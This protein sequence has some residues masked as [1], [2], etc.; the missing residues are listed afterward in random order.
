MLLSII[1]VNWNTCDL[2]AQCLQTL[3]QQPFRFEFDIWVVDNASTD[4]SLDMLRRDFPQ[5]RLIANNTNLGFARANNQALAQS[6]AQYRLL[7]NSDAFVTPGAIESMLQLM[8][9]HPKAGLVGAR[10]LNPDGSFQTSFTS[11]PNLWQEFLVLSG[12]GRLFKG[13]WYPS[14]AAQEAQGAQ[15]VDYVSGACLLVRREAYAQVGGMD[16][17]YFMYAEEMDWCFAMR[18]NGWQVWYQPAAKILHVG[19]GSSQKRPIQREA[20]LYCSRVRFFRKHYGAAS[21]EALK[22]MLYGFTTLKMVG[23]ATLRL[24]SGGKR[25]RNVVPVTYLAAQLGKV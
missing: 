3:Y 20:D 5:V 2:L 6:E 1:I 23:H 14:H 18:Q 17:A 4:G 25:G 7:F 11:F 15:V 19:G 9:D 22:W 21:A 13:P 12:L 10:L 24:I 16:E 8:A